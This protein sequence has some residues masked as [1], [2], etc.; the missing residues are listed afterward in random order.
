MLVFCVI[1]GLV[2]DGSSSKSLL[3]QS[4]ATANSERSFLEFVKEAQG[5][6]QVL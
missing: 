4:E 3:P 2:S 5:K 1:S 6:K